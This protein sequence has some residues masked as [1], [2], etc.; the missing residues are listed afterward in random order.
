MK[1]FLVFLLAAWLGSLL[2]A[3]EKAPELFAVLPARDGHVGAIVV[4]GEQSV[5]INSAYGAVRISGGRQTETQ[6]D[7]ARVRETF[8]DTIDALPGS[9][10]SFTLYVLGGRDELPDESKAQLES[11][12][13][14]RKRRPLPDVGVIR[15]T[16]PVA[17]R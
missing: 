2:R 8:G 17:P 15:P 13:A 4:K 1:L 7:E 3:P 10:T 16:V 12:F 11:V 6:V 9:T 5:V 14:E